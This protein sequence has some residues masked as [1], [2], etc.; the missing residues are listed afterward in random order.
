MRRTRRSVSINIFQRPRSTFVAIFMAIGAAL[1]LVGQDFQSGAVRLGLLYEPGYVP[2]LVIAPIV[3]DSALEEIAAQA[4]E[5]IRRDLYFSDRFEIIQV[6][7]SLRS[8]GPPN[9]ALWNQLGAVWLVTSDVS[10]PATSPILRVGLHDVV[11][12]TLKSIQA[13]SLPEIRS[14]DFRMALHRA[15]DEIV[16]WATEGEQGIAATRIAFRR[17]SNDGMWALWVIDSDG[18]NAQ[19][20][21]TGAYNVFSP[22]FSPDGSRIA[23]TIQDELGNFALLETNRITGSQRT[24]ASGRLLLTPAYAPDGRLAYA[25]LVGSGA[26]VTLEGVGW[27]TDTRGDALNPTF[28]PDGQRFAFEADPTGEP[29]VY[30]KP[31]SGGQPRRISVYVRNERTNAVGPDWSPNGGRITYAAMNGGSFQ[32]FTVNPDGTDRRMLTSRGQN[33]APSWAPDGRHIVFESVDVRGRTIW[34]LDTVTG[35]SR[36]LTSGQLDYLPDWSPPLPPGS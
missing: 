4:A 20:A 34:I 28:S 16:S 14:D 35:R 26:E 19:R 10:G 7:D 31:V 15:A 29:Q 6:P 18:E 9:Y 23:Y 3:A 13:F 17:G 33:E 1:P 25:E 5:I 8:E 32:I 11:Y 24:I 12:G 30:V 2:A 22:A 27:I 36:V 21:S